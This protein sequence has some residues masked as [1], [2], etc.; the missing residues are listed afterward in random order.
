MPGNEFVRNQ[1]VIGSAAGIA[2]LV[3]A[4]GYRFLPSFGGGY[5]GAEKPASP[6]PSGTPMSVQ[7]PPKEPPPPAPVEAP[8]PEAAPAPAAEPAP[9]AP[10]PP[11]AIAA[12]LRKA[13]KAFTDGHLI[14]PRD[15]SALAQYQKV[16][17]G[18]KDNAAAKAGIEKIHQALL[19]QAKAALDRDDDNDS[20]RAIAALASLP[21]VQASE[22]DAL[23][24]RLKLLRRISPLLTRAAD[25]MKQGQVTAPKDANALAVYRDVL[26]LDPDNKLAAQGLAQVQ[27]GFLDRALAAAAQDDFSG[28]DAILAEGSGIAP[29][30][31]ELLDTRTR[32]EG[33]RRQRA[34]NVLA[35]ANSALDAGNAD[36]AQMLA[37][38]ALGLSPDVAGVDEFNEHL[39]NARLYASYKP[40]Q[41]INDKFLDRSGSAP[42]VVVIPT[43]EFTMGSPGS[44]EGHRSN[45]E[46]QRQVKI[47]SGFALGANDVTVAQFRAFVSDADY[48]TDAEKL[49]S[50]GVYDEESGR[51]IERH[52]ASWKDDFL[53]ERATDNLPVVHV[54]WNDARAYAQWLAART[55]KNY[56]LPS[57]AEF[58][59]ALRAGGATRYPWGD[60]N[61]TQ[62]YANLTGDGD[63]SPHLRRSWAHAFPKYNDG[64][65]GPSPVGSFAP[66]KFGLQDI[67][68]NVSIW[69][70]D[71]WHEN[72]MRAPADSRAWINPGCAEH[73]VRGGSCG[74]APDQSRSAFR[75][76]APADTRSAR[77]GIRVA[78]DL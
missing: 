54:S 51:I 25:L 71:C 42:A 61:P 58:E 6:I 63:R 20:E 41:I 17:D 45:E 5:S 15:T 46:P 29:G 73:V 13:D 28:A 44:E 31:Q 38:R 16:L 4:L 72:Y 66:N 11:K 22:L 9:P 33:I 32:I 47:G 30:S 1:N 18:D 27:R 26:K 35:Q 19:D 23:Q 10:P 36:L 68:G 37:Q 55:S 3:F 49:G 69:I 12:L 59:Y 2:L 56:R 70:E 48:V 57:E 62:V 24:A 77:V 21:Q 40:G 60:K 64:F 76:A 14:E 78:R 7:A 50:S 8:K 75:I 52:G 67:D 43:G 74:S 39:R 34:A 65:W 53:G